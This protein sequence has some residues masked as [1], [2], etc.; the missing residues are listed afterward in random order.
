MQRKR[1]NAFYKTNINENNEEN[2]INNIN[3]EEGDM[4]TIQKNIIASQ[5]KHLKNIEQ[6]EKEHIEHMKS[7]LLKINPKDINSNG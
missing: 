3:K 1:Q 6:N 5:D 7:C 2:K 4:N